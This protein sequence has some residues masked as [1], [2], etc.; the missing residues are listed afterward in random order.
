MRAEMELTQPLMGAKKEQIL[1][2][3]HTNAREFVK[4]HKLHPEHFVCSNERSSN[5][6]SKTHQDLST[7]HPAHSFERP[8]LYQEIFHLLAE[9]PYCVGFVSA[10]ND[11]ERRTH[12]TVEQRTN[13]THQQKP[14]R[15]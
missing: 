15:Q 6:N 11:E 5:R 9:T 8:T 12:C 10:R 3:S 1:E 14:A 13:S 4:M 2:L 7:V